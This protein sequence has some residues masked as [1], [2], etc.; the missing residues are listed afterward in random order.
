MEITRR[1]FLEIIG[2][3]AA[4]LGLLSLKAGASKSSTVS[5]EGGEIKRIYT[6]C[7]MCKSHCAM[8]AF[9]KEGRLIKLE[10]NPDDHHGK[11]F[12]INKKGKSMLDKLE[13]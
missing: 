2:S 1:R 7:G 5:F 4:G 9:V 10:G 12:V 8:I 6:T 3:G 11:L 13:K